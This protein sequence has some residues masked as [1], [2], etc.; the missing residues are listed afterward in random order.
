M[1]N[2]ILVGMPGSGKSTVGKLLAEKCGKVFS[3][4]DAGIVEA[5]GKSIPEI[6]AESGEP[7]FRGWETRVLAELGKRS[8]IVLAT[9]GGCVTKA[10]NYPLLHQN[11]TIFCLERSLDRLPTDGRPLSQANKLEEMYRIRKPLYDQFADHIIDNNGPAE[12]AVQ[13]IL[14]LWEEDL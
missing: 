8:G 4:A 13:S 10:E 9:G 14:T 11:G 6:F 2:I 1:E 3:D 7:G 12:A 5:A